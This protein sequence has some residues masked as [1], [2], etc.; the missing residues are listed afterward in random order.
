M[1]FATQKS[2][3]L[4]IAILVLGLI[5][6]ASA[7]DLLLE[8]QSE[9]LV[10]GKY[11]NS[12][13]SDGYL[14][15]TTA[16]GLAAFDV[17][18]PS[19][20][21][22]VS[23]L[24]TDGI[25]SGLA[26]IPGG[27]M[28]VADGYNGLVVVDISDVTAPFIVGHLE[29]DDGSARDLFPDTENF[30]LFVALEEGGVAIVDVFNPAD[31]YLIAVYDTNIDR[32]MGLDYGDD[33]LFIG[34]ISSIQSFDVTINTFVLLDT[35]IGVDSDYLGLWGQDDMLFAANGAVGVD[36]FD[37]SDPADISYDYSI[38]LGGFASFI[39]GME[40]G[41]LA[42]ACMG[43]GVYITDITGVTT[44]Q[45]QTEDEAYGV[46]SIDNIVYTGIG[47]SGFEIIDGVAGTIEGGY[48]FLGGPVNIFIQ[49]GFAYVADHAGGLKVFDVTDPRDPVLLGTGEIED[50]WA[51]DVAVVGDYAFV[52]AFFSGLH[53]FDV[54]NPA[55]PNEVE[56][57]EVT[58]EGSRACALWGD[59]YL[60]MVHYELGIIKL[61]I[62]DPLNVGSVG[63]W[64]ATTG[65]PKDVV[66]DA[67]NDFAFVADYGEVVTDGVDVYD[68]SVGA[69][70][71]VDQFNLPNV[72]SVAIIVAPPNYYLY[73]G[74]ND[75]LLNIFEV[76]GLGN[77]TLVNTFQTPG[78]ING[79]E[80]DDLYYVYVSNW[81]NGMEAVY[82]ADPTAPVEAGYYDTHSLG[83]AS[84]YHDN[85]IYFAD[86]YSMYIFAL[87]GSVEVWLPDMEAAPGEDIVIPLT[88]SETTG[89][90]ITAVDMTVTYDVDIIN[91]DNYDAVGTLMGDAFWTIIPNITPGSCIVGGG[92]FPPFGVPLTGSGTLISLVGTV[93]PTATTGETTDLTFTAFMFNSGRPVAYTYNGSVT[94]IEMYSISGTVVYYDELSMVPDVVLDLTGAATQTYTTGADGFYEFTNLASGYYEVA[95]HKLEVPN[96]PNVD[97]SDA[98]TT[99]QASVGL[100]TLGQYDSLAAEV[101]GEGIISFDDAVWIAW[102]AVSLEPQFPIA[103]A[104][105]SDWAFVPWGNTYDPLTGDV[106]DDYVG[107]LYGDVFTS[108]SPTF[109][110]AGVKPIRKD[111]L[112]SV[113][114]DSYN[115]GDVIY[116]NIHFAGDQ[117][118]NDQDNCFLQFE[119]S[120]NPSRVTF[121]LAHLTDLTEGWT[122]PFINNDNEIGL[123]K[124]GAFNVYQLTPDHVGDIMMRL[125]FKA[126]KPIKEIPVSLNSYQTTS[127][128]VY[129][130]SF[131]ATYSL[132][133]NY[134]NP[135][136]SSTIISYSLPIGGEVTLN[137]YNT[138]GQKVR[139]LFNGAQ[140][141]G[142]YQQAFNGRDDNGVDLASGIY[143][144]QIKSNSYHKTMKM[145]LVR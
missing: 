131:P 104:N 114:Q 93:D 125:E 136:N 120:Y 42:V 25:S 35:Y 144:Y 34:D 51:Y 26:P 119:M 115:E 64:V 109:I 129:E 74:G 118:Q 78:D 65:M 38:T 20:P 71:I 22:L 103:I 79:L 13:Y 9:T 85:F 66:V 21:V 110:A 96:N 122:P 39:S 37:V 61:D 100:Y 29:F 15:V 28:C 1:T 19:A 133:Q 117:P 14:F 69:P 62:S 2:R 130:A 67:V 108:W 105:G 27:Y 139:T 73:A 86:S 111:D 52:V 32:V 141:I 95:M 143:F 3:I 56:V 142:Y 31:P 121:E 55:S 24:G 83:K 30:R 49:D 36:V 126:N 41:D 43:A 88:V 47:F 90:D 98:V 107:I 77:L 45:V 48:Y 102:Y 91:I 75:G 23:E 106:V 53:V 58:E 127:G 92:A 16:Y 44:L 68:I 12:V 4:I 145:V 89:L 87:G 17:S 134:P 11:T 5:G 72:R 10:T 138:L 135:F 81:A 116:V 137:I 70:V 18:A 101:T 7:Q 40:N 57:F 76:D 97:F 63:D 33:I 132:A 124:G 54:S 8:M 84:C 140:R 80:V 46:C 123:I 113:D 59:D 60:I 112:L 128:K 82:V 50:D 94:V 99:A 6:I